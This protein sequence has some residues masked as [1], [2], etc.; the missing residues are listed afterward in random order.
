VEENYQKREKISYGSA[1]K[2]DK[3]GWRGDCGGSDTIIVIGTYLVHDPVCCP[4]IVFVFPR[5][6]FH[7]HSFLLL[8]SV[9]IVV[10]VVVIVRPSV[11][12][13]HRMILTPGEHLSLSRMG[14]A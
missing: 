3:V 12:S 11:V 7:R 9:I 2:A 14:H 4:D 8:F 10:V 6:L 5:V 1:A 13:L